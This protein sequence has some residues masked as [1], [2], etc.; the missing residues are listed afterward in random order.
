MVF[1]KMKPWLQIGQSKHFSQKEHY[2]P[3]NKVV[4]VFNTQY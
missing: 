3:G 2:H 1:L 4:I